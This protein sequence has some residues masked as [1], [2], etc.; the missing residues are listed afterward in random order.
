MSEDIVFTKRVSKSGKGYL[1]WIPKDVSLFLGIDESI[2]LEL[3]I[4][5]LSSPDVELPFVKKVSKS[6]RGYLIWISKDITEYLELNDDSMVQV[7]AKKLPKRGV[8]N[9]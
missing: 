1:V 4:K 7:S 6:G 8:V 2:T 5:S 3:K 9:E